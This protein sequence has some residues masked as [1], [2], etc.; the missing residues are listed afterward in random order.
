MQIFCCRPDIDR[1]TKPPVDHF[2]STGKSGS[3]KYGLK[4]VIVPRDIIVKFLS[5]AE[6]NTVR[7]IE[8][9]GILSGKFVSTK[10]V[11]KCMTGRFYLQI[12]ILF[13][14]IFLRNHLGL[15][16]YRLFCEGN[17]TVYG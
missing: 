5:I 16:L 15:M 9:C 3:N 6:P 2:L 17:V 10:I 7:N 11:L 12:Y 13:Y 1:S 8:T 14:F 4:D